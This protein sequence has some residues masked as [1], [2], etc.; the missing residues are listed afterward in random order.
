MAEVDFQRLSRRVDTIAA[1]ASAHSKGFRVV[2]DRLAAIEKKLASLEQ[3]VVE[4]A[5]G[6]RRLDGH[7]RVDQLEHAPLADVDVGE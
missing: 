5:V 7:G 6:V 3:L 4:S 1:Q 2:C